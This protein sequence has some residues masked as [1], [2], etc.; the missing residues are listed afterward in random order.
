VIKSGANPSLKPVFLMCLVFE[1]LTS[2]N[3]FW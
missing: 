1:N 3:T 2:T